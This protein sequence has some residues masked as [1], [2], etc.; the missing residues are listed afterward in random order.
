[1]RRRTHDIH[2]DMPIVPVKS[3]L[4]AVSYVFFFL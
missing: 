3:L 1:M 2:T 4:D